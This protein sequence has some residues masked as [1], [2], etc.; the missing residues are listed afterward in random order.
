MAAL[1]MSSAYKISAESPVEGCGGVSSRSKGA[2]DFVLHRNQGL[3][4][5]AVPV[6]HEGQPLLGL[7][8]LQ[9]IAPDFLNARPV[10]QRIRTTANAV[11]L[12]PIRSMPLGETAVVTVREGADGPSFTHTLRTK[13]AD[14]CL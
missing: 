8:E 7:L 5:L 4:L 13:D 11:Q 6:D 2:E 3:H 12:D 14:E 10:P 1:R 9:V